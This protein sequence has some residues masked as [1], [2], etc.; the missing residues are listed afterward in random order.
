MSIPKQPMPIMFGNKNQEVNI[1]DFLNKPQEAKRTISETVLQEL[2]KH[3][4][5]KGA[6]TGWK[7]GFLTGSLIM[8]VIATIFETLRILQ[9]T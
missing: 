8:L 6:M 5:I 7:Y 9:L 4:Y 3:E 1:P 2:L